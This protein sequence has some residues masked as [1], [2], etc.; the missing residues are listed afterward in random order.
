MNWG[1]GARRSGMVSALTKLANHGEFVVV[2]YL[3]FADAS[4]K[5]SFA[6][7]SGRPFHGSLRC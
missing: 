5:S 3:D 6:R 7:Q 2:C 1:D 4:M